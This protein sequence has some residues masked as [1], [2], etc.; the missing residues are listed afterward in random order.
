MINKS[1]KFITV[2]NKSTANI[3]NQLKLQEHILK[4]AIYFS[5]DSD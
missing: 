4:S 5:K 3:I 1:K 2:K